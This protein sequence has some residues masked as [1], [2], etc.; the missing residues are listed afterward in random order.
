[1]GDNMNENT[2][3][4]FKEEYGRKLLVLAFVLAL[5][6]VSFLF[7]KYLLPLL[8]P[9]IAGLVLAIIIKPVV[10]FLKKYLH[11]NKMIGTTIV[12]LAVTAVLVVLSGWLIRGVLAQ[13]SALLE[14][15]D[16]YM[17][18]ADDYLCDICNSVGDA[19][20]MEGESLFR[21]VSDNIDNFIGEM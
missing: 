21:T 16:I 15:M 18:S 19:V 20:G 10:M 4:K 7:L 2:R 13:V 8:W 9:F 12:I 17:D 6:L 14:N 5:L 11:I 1:M 3:K